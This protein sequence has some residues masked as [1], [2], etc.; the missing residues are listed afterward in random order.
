MTKKILSAI[1]CLA[2]AISIFAQ[3]IDLPP[4]RK[5][6]FVQ[7]IIEQYYVDTVN[8]EK[9]ATEAITAMLKTLDPHSTYTNAED[10]RALTEPLQG[11]FQ[12]HWNT[13]QYNRRHNP[14]GSDRC[15]RAFGKGRHSCGRQTDK[16]KR[17]PHFRRENAAGRGNETSARGKRF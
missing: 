13:I 1:L 3:K 12:R 6:A 5:L 8:G 7:Q 17:H 16:R 10:T 15:R 14:G 9:V 4:A 2:S 11:N